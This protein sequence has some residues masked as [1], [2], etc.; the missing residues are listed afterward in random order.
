MSMEKKR[1]K[2]VFQLVFSTKFLF[3]HI[4]GYNYKSVEKNHFFKVLFNITC[5]FSRAVSDMLSVLQYS[6]RQQQNR[7]PRWVLPMYFFSNNGL[8]PLF[9]A[10]L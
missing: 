1:V 7:Q 2:L 6:T 5:F 4:L 9:E 10:Q 8:K 3:E